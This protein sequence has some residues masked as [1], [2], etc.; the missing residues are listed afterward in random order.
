MVQSNVTPSQLIYLQRT[1]LY[2]ILEI[3]SVFRLITPNSSIPTQQTW[4]SGILMHACVQIHEHSIV[5]ASVYFISYTSHSY[6]YVTD[7][8]IQ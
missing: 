4:T 1:S 3:L 8:L 2:I 7:N 5:M 6:R